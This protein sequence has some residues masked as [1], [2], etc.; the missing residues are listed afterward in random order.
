MFNLYKLIKN[1]DLCRITINRDKFK[2]KVEGSCII[3]IHPC[4]NVSKEE[5]III[6]KNLKEITTILR[7]NID[8]IDKI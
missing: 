7:N 4:L 5:K 6:E 2:E 1:V 3:K 8:D